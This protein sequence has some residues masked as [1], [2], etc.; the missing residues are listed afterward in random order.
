MRILAI[1]GQNLAS[2]ARSFEI[3][4]A[5][6]A[7]AGVGL[8]AITG[9]VGAGKST[10]LDA[11]CL[12]L[13]DCTPRLRG[14]GAP[15]VG[16]GDDPEAWL[17][18]NDPRTLLRR[19]ASEGH[20]EVDFVGR[21][22]RRYR[23]RWTVRRARRRV[24]GRIQEQELSLRDLDRDLV[25]A[26]GRR[27]EVLAAVAARLG[28]DFDQFCRSVLLAQGDFAAFLEAPPAERARLLEA[29]TGADIYR[30]LSRQA[31]ERARAAQAELDKLEAQFAGNPP[32][33]DTERNLRDAEAAN[34]RTQLDVCRV[35]T[36]VASRYVAWH[37][38]AEEHRHREAVASSALQAALGADAAAAPERARLA[39]LQRAI[40][41]LA[42]WQ[43]AARTRDEA[44]VAERGLAAAS[45][46]LR[47]ARA[48]AAAAKGRLATALQAMFGAALAEP[49]PVLVMDPAPWL[50]LLQQAWALAAA[51]ATAVLQLPALERDIAA[52]GSALAAAEQ[53]LRRAVLERQAASAASLA[54][55]QAIDPA[56]TEAMHQRRQQLDTARQELVQQRS[57]V[58]ALVRAEQQVAAVSA[59]LTAMSAAAAAARRHEAAAKHA[60]QH[61]AEAVAGAQ[62]AAA[63]QQAHASFG[64]LRRHLHAGEACPLCGALEHPSPA[65]VDASELER[66]NANARVAEA[67]LAMRAEALQQA[68]TERTFA[69]REQARLIDDLESAQKHF[70]TAAAL[71]P[72]GD[73]GIGVATERL[74]SAERSLA[75][76][77]AAARAAEADAI[78]RAGVLQ[79]AHQAERAAVALEEQR[80]E[81]HR[82]AAS[83]QQAAQQ[84]LER[85]QLIQRDQSA[86]AARLLA[87]LAPACAGIPGGAATL[88]AGGE[89]L[90]PAFRTLLGDRQQVVDAEAAVARAVEQ[91]LRAEQTFQK[92]RRE[93]RQQAQEF[94]RALAAND[95]L[96]DDVAAAAK[97]GAAGVAATS[98][99]LQRLQEDVI[100]GRAVLHEI[101]DQRQQ[102]ENRAK[103]TL[104]AEDAQQALTLA[105]D[106]AR[107]VAE[108]LQA[109]QIDLGTDDLIRRQRDELAPRVAAAAAEHRTWAA[110]DAL[111]GSSTG[112]A[113]AVFAQ[114]LTLDLLLVEANRRLRELAR[115][116]QLHKN[117]G[118]DLDIVVVDLDLG[119]SRRG[120]QSLSGGET[121][122]VSLALALALATLAAPKSRVETLFLDE[123]F[124][125]LDAES[126]EVAIGALDSLQASGCQV[127]VISHVDG[128]AERIGAQVNV[129]PDG[130]GRS[131]VVARG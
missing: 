57:A 64:A 7:L 116:Y 42:H 92:A 55:T 105:R 66:A 17:R 59:A 27:S 19:D 1:R 60:H 82:H 45:D 109:V 124:G 62:Q 78:A 127:G 32:L 119:G 35:A 122:L 23:A 76:D 24:D 41:V 48:A 90:L 100:R 68:T 72:G 65:I 89:A 96:A 14:R 31:H 114:G 97:A 8:F 88:L 4:L 44:V 12:P 10:L 36:L 54:A 111:I 49:L 37:E 38:Q 71:T 43:L 3:D 126:L 129:V 15:L 128:I 69:E 50:P 25:V 118:A 47:A 87:A 99:S 67:E 20:A 94:E 61:A 56:V 77:V 16:D 28:L 22:G 2:L 86:Q 98:R 53:A 29:L 112:D 103:P 113:F 115:R 34:L 33:P 18:A 11:L 108:R 63:R 74:A 93:E 52:A 104:D 95:V 21:D 80:R 81:T 123:G 84:L 5:Q 91:Q 130:G 73:L 117:S 120:L 9:P 30:R 79:R 75:Q 39:R 107:R 13:F 106:N 58:A 125:T 101:A 83:A 70:A 40:A 6:G 102:H 110:L 121:F 131:R 46:A 85:R 26:A 51:T